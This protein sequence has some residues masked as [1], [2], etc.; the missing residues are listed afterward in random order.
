MLKNVKFMPGIFKMGIFFFRGGVCRSF[1]KMVNMFIYTCPNHSGVGVIDTPDPFEHVLYP[2]H[3]L[4]VLEKNFSD[5]IWT[6]R[7]QKLP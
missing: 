3:I 5:D 7:P 2:Y 4:E 1:S 6:V